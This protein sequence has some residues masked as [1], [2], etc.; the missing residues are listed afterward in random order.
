MITPALIFDWLLRVIAGDWAFRARF[1]RRDAYT[2]LVISLAGPMVRPFPSRIRCVELGCSRQRH[3]RGTPE[4]RQ[5]GG[6]CIGGSVRGR[7][8]R[9]SGVDA[10]DSLQLR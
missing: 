10:M 4:A 7:A 2:A 9:L 5:R 8:G 6:E 3:A 1:A